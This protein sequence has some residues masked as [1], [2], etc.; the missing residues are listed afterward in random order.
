MAGPIAA[1]KQKIAPD[2]LCYHIWGGE[3]SLEIAQII[4]AERA[5]LK[6]GSALLPPWRLKNTYRAGFL[7][8]TVRHFVVKF[9]TPHN[10]PMLTSRHNLR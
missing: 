9:S 6:G 4:G 10:L 5:Y 8:T 2:S 1:K 7:K 3:Y